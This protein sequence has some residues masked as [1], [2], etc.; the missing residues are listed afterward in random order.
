MTVAVPFGVAVSPQ[1]A[2]HRDR[3]GTGGPDEIQPADIGAAAEADAVMDGDAAGGVLAGTYPD[4]SFAA[5]MATQAELDARIRTPGTSLPSSPADGQ[6]FYD[7]D[8]DRLH[9][10]NGTAW[11][12]I[13]PI[14]A[15]V[16]T[17]QTTGSTSYADL[18][19][20]G[21]AVSVQT[22]TRALVTSTALVNHDT[23]GGFANMSFAVSGASTV[24]A[25]DATAITQ[26]SA[27]AGANITPSG[28]F[29]VTG[30]TAGVNTFTAKYRVGG[31]NGAWAN[32]NIV[33]VGLP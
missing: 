20:A 8:D 12:C 9:V 17:S 23:N 32:R 5:D 30:L 27:V 2:N 11:V 33:V 3:H 15:T 22:G 13:T 19:T 6:L 29:L 25:A 16:A 26:T 7:T 31:G 4:P 1:R 21:P 18:A 28:T 24:A 10:Y 14:A